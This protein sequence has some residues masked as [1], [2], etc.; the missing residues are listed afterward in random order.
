MDGFLLLLAIGWRLLAWLQQT[1]DAKFEKNEPSKPVSDP[2]VEALEYETL[3]EVEQSHWW[4]QA[5][6]DLLRQCLDQPRFRLPL[7]A[8][9]L[10]AGCGT[11]ANLSFLKSMLNPGYLG[12]FDIAPRAAQWT[13]QK[14]PSADVYVSDICDPMLHRAQYDLILSCD[15]I[16]I[17]GIAASIEGL[18]RLV[19]HLAPGGIFVL[20]VPAY[21]WLYSDHDRAVHTRERFHRQQIVALLA[22]LGLAREIVTYRLCGLF[23]LLVARRLP[24]I[25][26][27]TKK[28]SDA[29]ELALPN[30]LINSLLLQ[31]MRVENLAI[32]SNLRFPFGSSIFAV[33]RKII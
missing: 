1:H 31:V 33:G 27:L 19:E 13:K 25:L 7:S 21:Q 29:S 23:P 32:A 12:G 9:V 6:R 10:D 24:S 11:G 17:P 26:R 4:F 5:F 16:Y 22:E 2:S 20:N 30:K 18:K 14:C 15:V 8:S 28:S 3:S